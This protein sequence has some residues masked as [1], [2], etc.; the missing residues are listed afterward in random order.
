MRNLLKSYNVSALWHFTDKRNQASILAN[1][2]LLSWVEAVRRRL[3]V[4]APGGND[5]S[6]Q[7]DQKFG[8]DKFVHLAFIKNHPMLHIAKKEGRIESPIWV[9]IDVSVLDLAGVMY[10]NDVANKSGVE[11]LSSDQA[12][13]GVDFQAL[14]TRM[15]WSDEEVM[16]R[17]RCAE[18]SEVLVPTIV[19]IDYIRDFHNG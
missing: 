6:H 17:R 13:T 5:W 14:Y 10:T 2:G 11:I 15:D 4:P 7:A 8:V 3:V 18:K 9:E 19:P 12:K 1:G 16:R